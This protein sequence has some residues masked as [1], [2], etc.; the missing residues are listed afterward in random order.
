MKQRMRHMKQ[1]MKSGKRRYFH[2]FVKNK[3]INKIIAE[4]NTCD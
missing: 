4:E 1:G 2:D 3:A